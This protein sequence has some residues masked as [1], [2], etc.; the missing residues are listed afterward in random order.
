MHADQ[1]DI[2][3]D[4]VRRLVGG[5]F[6]QWADLP[7]ERLTS[8]GTVNAVYRLGDALTVR[9]PLTE[10]GAKDLERE[11]RWLPRL[12]PGLPV[13]I[14]TVVA[15][16]EAAEGYP[17]AW[18]VHR[19]IEGESPVEG[20]LDEPELLAC[21][22]AGFIKAM[23]N[24]H[25]E[26]GPLAYR[27]SPLAKVDAQTRAAIEGLRH[28]EE[29]FDADVAMAAWQDALAARPWSA[30]PRWAHSDLMP[31]NLLVARGRLTAVLDFATVGVGDPA[32]DLI[33]AWNLLPSSARDVFRDAVD[34]DDA[35]WAR[36]RGWALAM[37]VIQ[38]PYYR[39]TNAII[40]ANARH[41][42]RE[43][44]ASQGADRHETLRGDRTRGGPRRTSTA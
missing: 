18:S 8:G 36:G 19:W 22:L 30:A 13:I 11:Q 6:P 14:P 9:L 41:V 43:V 4:L 25:V 38:L 20:H 2:D 12:A 7:V 26:G 27:G 42:I 39:D 3:T 35:T 15:T 10:G 16:G 5:R 44:L 1:T 40:S 17:W 32:C 21:D 37:A 28:A 33:P 29:D 23:R 24:T 31:S 34:V